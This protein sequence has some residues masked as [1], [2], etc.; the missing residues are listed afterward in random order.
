MSSTRSSMLGAPGVSESGN[1]APDGTTVLVA[2]ATVC[3][4]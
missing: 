4:V 1:A 2:M 3:T